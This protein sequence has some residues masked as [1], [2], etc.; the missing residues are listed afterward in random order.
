MLVNRCTE[1]AELIGKFWKLFEILNLD[2]DV[3]ESC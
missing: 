2:V 3:L 1:K